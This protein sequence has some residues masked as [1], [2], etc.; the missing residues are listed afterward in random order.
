[1]TTRVESRG[2][3]IEQ[4]PVVGAG[5]IISGGGAAVTLPVSLLRNA[6]LPGK[7]DIPSCH[8]GAGSGKVPGTTMDMARCGSGEEIIRPTA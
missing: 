4:R 2:V 3:R 6:E 1:M 5:S 7:I 8:Q